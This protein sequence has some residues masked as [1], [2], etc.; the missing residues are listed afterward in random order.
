M[1]IAKESDMS[2]SVKAFLSR[3]RTRLADKK[4]IIKCNVALREFKF[5]NCK[6]DVV[7]YNNREKAFYVVEC[8][9]GSDPVSIGHAFGQALAYR[10]LLEENGFEF[11]RKFVNE[12]LA[13][14]VKGIRYSDLED[15]VNK[16]VSNFRFYV[17]L[18]ERACMKYKLL[19]LIKRK[20]PEVGI[21]RVKED[22]ACRLYI[23]TEGNQKDYEISRSKL[24]SIS[25]KKKY[26][27]REDFFQEMEARLRKELD[28][29]LQQFKS[30]KNVYNYKQ[31]WYRSSSIHFE[32]WFGKK[33]KKIEIGLHLEST[34]KKNKELLQFLN[35]KRDELIQRIGKGIIIEPWYGRKVEWARVVERYDWDGSYRNLDQDLMDKLVK[36]VKLYIETLK[37]MIVAFEQQTETHY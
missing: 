23:R 22:G 7:G 13:K 33:N 19:K 18:R 24:V 27:T 17:A 2:D 5:S 12:L 4:A 36:R 1:E 16:P 29:D 25:F 37:P 31:F 34:S 9:F 15:L 21:I 30:N 3:G 26:K 20:L 8:K 32:V 6:F 10:C 35:A 14:S 11:K 28:K